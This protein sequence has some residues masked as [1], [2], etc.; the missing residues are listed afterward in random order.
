MNFVFESYGEQMKA[1]RPSKLG[2]V[3]RCG[4]WVCAVQYRLRGAALH[5]L[6]TLRCAA[7]K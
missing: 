5:Y 2:A 4:G 7:Q 3:M 1:H 6:S